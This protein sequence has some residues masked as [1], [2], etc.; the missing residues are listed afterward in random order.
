MQLL[1]LKQNV[2]DVQL[3]SALHQH[4]TFFDEEGKERKKERNDASE[5]IARLG[6]R[7]L[8]HTN[9]FVGR[10]AARVQ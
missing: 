6:I 2:K 8:L 7:L 1:C 9:F 4:S 3:I 5:I 10:A